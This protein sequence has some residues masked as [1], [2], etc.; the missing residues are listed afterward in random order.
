MAVA[1]NSTDFPTFSVTV[2]TT[3]PLWFYCR[4]HAPD[5][6]SHCGA[7]M[8]FAVNPVQTSARNFTAFANLAA[9]LNGTN[10]TSTPAASASASGS[11]ASTSATDTTSGAARLGVSVVLGLGSVFALAAALL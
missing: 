2:N 9:A 5:G 3:D 7:G 8:V 1:A 6:S 11:A 4:Q 10:A